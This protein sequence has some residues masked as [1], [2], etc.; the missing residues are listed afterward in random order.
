MKYKN[1]MQISLRYQNLTDKIRGVRKSKAIDYYKYL[2]E[3]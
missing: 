1:S 2:P 3:N